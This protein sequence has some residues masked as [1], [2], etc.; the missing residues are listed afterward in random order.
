MDAISV[1]DRISG[2]GW[3]P[4]AWRATS[5]RLLAIHPLA[6]A[7]YTG[8]RRGEV[9]GLFWNDIDLRARTLTVQRA[10]QITKNGLS[11]REP[12]TASGRR[13]IVLPEALVEALHR[14]HSEQALHRELIGGDP[15]SMCTREDGSP[16]H[17][18]RL[19][20]AVHTLV[21]RVGLPPVRLRDC[22]TLTPPSYSSR[23]F[24]RRLF[25]STGAL[26]DSGD[27]GHLQPP[28][29]GA[30]RESDQAIRRRHSGREAGPRLESCG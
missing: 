15:R 16:V 3:A 10:V 4:S 11:F 27:D 14:H 28:V 6:V 13:L 9:C 29:A 19:T 21:R 8:L 17:P 24:T 1:G 20:K 23:T 30:P 5:K 12:K 7:V 2:D 22:G 26:L 18:D 25:R